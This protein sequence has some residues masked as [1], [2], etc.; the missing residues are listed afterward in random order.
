MSCQTG[1]LRRDGGTS[2]GTLR[3]S[4]PRFPTYRKDSDSE[5]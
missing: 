4:Q 2:L 5:L 3:R 1:T